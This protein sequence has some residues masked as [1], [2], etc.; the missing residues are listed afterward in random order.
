MSPFDLVSLYGT[1]EALPLEM[2]LRSG[3]LS[4][5]LRGGQIVDLQVD[6]HEVWHGVAFL[7]RDPGWGTP[8]PVLQRLT[9]KAEGGVFMLQLEGFIP[10]EPVIDLSLTLS[11]DAHGTVQLHARAIPRGNILANRIG[12]CLMHPMHAIG[13]D[14]EV[15]HVD[16]RVST[17]VFPAR[18]PPWPPFTGIRGIRHEFAPGCWAQA[19]FK[20]E[21]FEFE[22]QRNNADASFKTYSRSN[23]LP[24]PY[25]LPGGVAIEQS[26]TLRIE[27]AAAPFSPAPAQDQSIPLLDHGNQ[28]AMPLLGLAISAADALALPWLQT[29]LAELS[30]ALLHLT[31]LQPEQTV[32]WGGIANLLSIADA[33]LRI[34][35]LADVTPISL[36]RLAVLLCDARIVPESVAVFPATPSAVNVTRLAF[37]DSAIGGGT[38]HF[39]AQFNRMGEVGATDFLSFTI[40]PTVHGADDAAPMIGLQSLPSLLTTAR[41]LY[42]GRDL[43]IGPSSLGARSSPLGQQPASD[44]TRRMALAQR[45][46][47]TRGLFGAAW[48][49]GHVAQAVRAGAQAVSVMSLS[50]D[51]GVLEKT[52]DGRLLRHPSFFVWLELARMKRLKAVT[53]SEA[54]R[55]VALTSTRDGQ[56]DCLIANLTAQAVKLQLAPLAAVRVMDVLTWQAYRKDRADSPWR[57]V[58]VSLD[59]VLTLGAFGLAVYK[60]HAVELSAH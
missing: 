8:Q 13:R 60:G 48:L 53:V 45:D 36:A 30:P 27:S 15:E 32:H 24:R 16:G 3:P 1:D 39:F 6:G 18:I 46:P 17:G 31:L 4:M 9:Q 56:L 28:L 14:L 10:C 22:D 50:G 44:G 37:P 21:D 29:A 2:G 52:V 23:T 49:L 58:I 11:G 59:G 5:T 47:R 41:E 57:E 20:G 7:Y 12:L 33:R 34:D 42:P 19:Q 38:P 40:C 51:A 54:H 25:V 26:L 55:V 35:L 43:R